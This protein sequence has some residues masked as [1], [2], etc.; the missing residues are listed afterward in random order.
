MTVWCVLCAGS[1]SSVKSSSGKKTSGRNLKKGKQRDYV[2]YLSSFNG[3][4][5]MFIFAD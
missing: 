2:F 5:D 3:L 1:Y 4:P